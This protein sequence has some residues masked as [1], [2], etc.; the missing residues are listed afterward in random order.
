MTEIV[1]TTEERE[2]VEI[3]RMA[4]AIHLATPRPCSEY[5]WSWSVTETGRPRPMWNKLP[6]CGREDYRTMA[7]AARAAMLGSVA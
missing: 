3:E 6:E 2:T 4:K 5:G 1:L 7:R